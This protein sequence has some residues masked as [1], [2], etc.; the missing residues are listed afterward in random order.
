MKRFFWGLLITFLASSGF[1]QTKGFINVIT[2]PHAATS[3]PDVNARR[4]LS[5]DGKGKELKNCTHFEEA[6]S[7]VFNRVEPLAPGF[8]EL[9]LR[10]SE[11]TVG[12]EITLGQLT[13]VRVK[14]F[15]FE[16]L[17]KQIPNLE[18]YEGYKISIARDYRNPQDRLARDLQRRQ[19]IAEWV[20]DF[21]SFCSPNIPAVELLRR[22][23]VELCVKGKKRIFPFEIKA[24]LVNWWERF[25]GNPR[26]GIY[27]DDYYDTG[28]VE[29]KTFVVEPQ[30]VTS[31]DFTKIVARIWPAGSNGVSIYPREPN[32]IAILPGKYIIFIR[33]D[34][35]TSVAKPIDLFYF[36]VK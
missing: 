21:E 35:D 19:D 24:D 11:S 9:W 20:W 26:N 17:T 10:S 18:Y 27:I 15:S 33:H 12:V 7:F 6:K 25:Q 29:S 34:D 32:R 30:Y 4:C 2:S 16:E 1:A 28:L 22:G 8:Y 31:G 36:E 13:E 3:Y 5:F 14:S 23:K